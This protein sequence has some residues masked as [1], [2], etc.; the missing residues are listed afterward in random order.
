MAGLWL[1]RK[2]TRH[3]IL[4]VSGGRPYPRIINSGGRLIAENCKFYSGVR[5]E[6]GSDA[7]LHIKNG[8][9]INRNTLIIAQNH[10]HIGKDCKISWDVIILDTDMHPLNS[11]K[12]VNKPVIIED[13]VWIGCRSIILKGVTIGRGAVVAAGSVV[14]KNIPPYTI[15]GGSPARHLADVER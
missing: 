15:A 10:V 7:V 14:T 8:T 12:V 6:I 11:E 5:M 2:F 3:G 13:G 9:Y 1:S 4:V